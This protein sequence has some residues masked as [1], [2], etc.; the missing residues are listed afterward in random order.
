MIAIW[1]LKVTEPIEY[2]WVRAMKN[3]SAS[4]KR[5]YR[6]IVNGTIGTKA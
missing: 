5:T 2:V 6:I 3:I 1:V 4:V